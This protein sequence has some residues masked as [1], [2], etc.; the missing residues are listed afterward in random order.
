MGLLRGGREPSLSWLLVTIYQRVHHQNL[1]LVLER[2]V[3]LAILMLTGGI[4]LL[5]IGIVLCVLGVRG[6]QSRSEKWDQEYP[7]ERFMTSVYESIPKAKLHGPAIQMLAGF[8]LF[9]AGV[10]CLM[11]YNHT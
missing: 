1:A 7:V 8:V 5:I 2:S 4:G 9:I 6:L 10:V 3:L 11:V